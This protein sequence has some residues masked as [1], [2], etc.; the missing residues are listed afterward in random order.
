MADETK[1]PTPEKTGTE[2]NTGGSQVKEPKS[3]EGVETT[4]IPPKVEEKKE[5]EPAKPAV[6]PEAPKTGTSEVDYKDKFSASTRRN[7]IVES[8]LVEL[9]KVL[10][11]VTRQEVPS[12]EEMKNADPDWD[13]RSDYE[14][15]NARKMVVLER[16]QGKILTTLHSISQDSQAAEKI[17]NFIA[18]EP[19]LKG[20]EEDFYKFATNP[21]NKGAEIDV[22][23]R[24]FLFDVKDEKPAPELPKEEHAPTLERGG[25]SGGSEKVQ[26]KEPNTF[27]SEEARQLRVSDQKKYNEL[28]RSGKL[29]IVD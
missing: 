6:A 22:L 3:G 18:S 14:K 21:K 19:R 28:V 8:Q 29:K 17:S 26:P 10:G 7:Q 13:F 24:A 11:D 4:P 25:S 12:D 9:Q 23:L 5:N 15:N 20:K 2:E 27:T 1:I 16:R